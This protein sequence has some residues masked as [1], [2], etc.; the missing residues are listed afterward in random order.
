[1][2]HPRISRNA[3][4]LS[5]SFEISCI[6]CFT[7][8]SGISAVGPLYFA[9]L[10]SCVVDQTT[11]PSFE[12]SRTE[13]QASLTVS[14]E[15]W[16]SDTVLL[17]LR[18]ARATVV[19]EPRKCNSCEV[20]SSAELLQPPPHWVIPLLLLMVPHVHERGIENLHS[21]NMWTGSGS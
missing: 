19:A 3:Y 20:F 10:L 12:T 21:A 16:E 18:A 8:L 11:S 9:P 6:S 15:A 1:M 5:S 4:L 14:V 13:A 17:V 7:I 2:P